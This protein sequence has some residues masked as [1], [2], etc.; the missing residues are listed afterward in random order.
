MSVQSVALIT[1]ST[2]ITSTKHEWW[3]SPYL[4]IFAGCS[5]SILENVLQHETYWLPGRSVSIQVGNP[6]KPGSGFSEIS[7]IERTWLC[8]GCYHCFLPASPKVAWVA[9]RDQLQWHLSNEI[10]WWEKRILQSFTTCSLH[11]AE[12]GKSLG[13]APSLRG[14][15]KDR[16]IIWLYFTFY[17]Y[18]ISRRRASQSVYPQLPVYFSSTRHFLIHT[19]RGSSKYNHILITRISC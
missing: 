7:W 8:Q 10:N 4:M 6:A 19:V 5:A 2:L 18:F 17:L 13:K 16:L 11:K 14:T 15:S 3:K 12:C 1:P 9:D